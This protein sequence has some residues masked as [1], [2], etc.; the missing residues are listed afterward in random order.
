[1][2]LRTGPALYLSEPLSTYRIHSGGAWHG[3]GTAYRLE[4]LLEIFDALNRHLGFEYDTTFRLNANFWRVHAENEALRR[5]AAAI[6][7]APAPGPDLAEAYA[8]V[9]NTRSYRLARR[10]AGVK[11]WVDRAVRRRAA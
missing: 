9:L 3:A 2:H 8:R 11:Q 5:A 6:P 7:P 10:L 1:L 4:K